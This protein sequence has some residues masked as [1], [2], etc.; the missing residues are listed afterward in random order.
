MSHEITATDHVLTLNKSAWHSLGTTLPADAPERFDWELACKTAQLDWRIIMGPIKAACAVGTEVDN[1]SRFDGHEQFSNQ[2]L[3]NR[4][5]IFR[6]DTGEFFD[7]VSGSYHPFQNDRLFAWFQPLLDSKEVQITTAGSLRGGRVVWAQCD[8]INGNV[9]ILPGDRVTQK[10]MLVSSHDKSC[11]TRAVLHHERVV[12]NN[13]LNMATGKNSQIM[14]VP[15]TKNQELA[16]GAVRDTLDTMRGQ[17]EVSIE[18]Y[19]KL[20]KYKVS[21]DG[22]VKFVEA[23]LDYEH[24]EGKK[25]TKRVEAVI[26]ALRNAPGAD[27]AQGTLWNAINALTYYTSHKSSDSADTRAFSQMFGSH[28]DLNDKALSI[29]AEIAA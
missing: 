1:D 12:C 18:Q 9:D 7:I 6:Q 17:F 24:K 25:R 8:I 22:Q 26:D 5:A 10:I 23:V 3:D 11:A 28:V 2:T 29:A 21:F 4:F 27:I 19:K 15:H 14:K 16:L 20:A 13:T